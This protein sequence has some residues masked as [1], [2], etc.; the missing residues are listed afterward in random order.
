MKRRQ[1][2]QVFTLLS[3]GLALP[4]LATVPPALRTFGAGPGTEYLSRDFF[5]ARL[6]QAFQLPGEGSRTLVLKG[7]ENCGEH[8][9]D[10]FR[11]VFE[12][13]AGKWLNEGIYRL[14]RGFIERFDLFLTES[15]RENAN[16]QLIAIINRQNHV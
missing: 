1:F 2:T 5:E 4:A 12:A 7:I 6:G 14:E 3:G 8:C 13:S 9:R 16:Q 10:Q 11:A 15:V